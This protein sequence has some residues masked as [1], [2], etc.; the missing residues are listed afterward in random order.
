[1]TDLGVARPVADQQQPVATPGDARP[2]ASDDDTVMSLVDH[3]TELRRRIFVSALAV[4]VGTVVGFYFAPAIVRLLVQPLPNK[5]V[6]FTELGGAFFLQVKIALVVGLALALPVVLY[7]F[8]AFVSPGLTAHERRVARPWVPLAMVFFL[9]GIVVAYFVLPYAVGFLLSFAL[10]ELEPFITAEKYFGFLQTLFLSFG[11]VMEFPIVLVL[12]NRIGIVPVSRLR[13]S[14][15]YVLLGIVI[16][17]VVATPGGD[18]V[19]PVIMAG[20]MYGLYEFTILI[21]R[22]SERG[23]VRRA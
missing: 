7:Q 13:S 8:W 20:V 21:L 17:A 15:R 1:M 3:L 22:R 6:V 9:V 23:E 4:L 5:R 18:P 12:L 19:S 14:R 16:F 11:I 10:P 2:P